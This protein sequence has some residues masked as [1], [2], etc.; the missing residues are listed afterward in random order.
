MKSRN[1]ISILDVKSIMPNY[2]V[3]NTKSGITAQDPPRIYIV[4]F[5]RVVYDEENSLLFACKNLHQ[6]QNMNSKLSNFIINEK[7]FVHVFFPRL[8]FGVEL[9]V[10][11]LLKKTHNIAPKLLFSMDA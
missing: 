8:K 9:Q 6:L 5:L 10:F 2:G 7:P 11:A 1:E 4:H 3:N